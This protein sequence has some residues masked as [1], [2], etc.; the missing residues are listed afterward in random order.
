MHR[1]LAG[2]S[3]GHAVLLKVDNQAPRLLRAI[4]LRVII[5]LLLKTE[6]VYQQLKIILSSP[7]SFLME[8]SDSQT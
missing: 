4:L 2:A 6:P 5:L 1:T 8:I 3:V 7:N